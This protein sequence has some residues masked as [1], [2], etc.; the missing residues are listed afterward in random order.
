MSNIQLE[1]ILKPKQGTASVLV[2][3]PTGPQI[4][5]KGQG[6]NNYICGACSSTICEN[7]PRGQII[8]LVFKCFK[9]GSYNRIRGT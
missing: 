4:M 5:I 6:G 8:N 9:C 1:V 7:V 2:P 3:G